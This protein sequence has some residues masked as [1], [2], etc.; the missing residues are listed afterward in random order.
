MTRRRFDS[1]PSST[2]FFSSDGAW[3]RT[4][5]ASPRA[6]SANAWP[7]PTGTVFSV[8]P[9]CC[10]NIGT[11]TSSRPESWVLVVV[12]RMTVRDAGGWA[13]AG[14]RASATTRR[15]TATRVTPPIMPQKA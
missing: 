15:A 2:Y 13:A 10:S 1:V 4:T 11:S 7:V 12:E 3:T 9:V 6:A 8:N 14:T 5:S